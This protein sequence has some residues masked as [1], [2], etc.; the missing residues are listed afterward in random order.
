MGGTSMAKANKKKA[1]AMAPAASTAAKTSMYCSALAV[2]LGA[3]CFASWLSVQQAPL[4]PNA[5]FP[6]HL[7]TAASAS[8]GGAVAA[9]EPV[10][11]R[12]RVDAG[13]CEVENAIAMRDCR[14]ACWDAP[15]EAQCK[16]W[17]RLGHC[18][19]ASAFMLMRCPGVCPHHEI[20][21]LRAAP[22]DT[23]AHCAAHAASGACEREYQRG[24]RYFLAQCFESCGQRAPRL[25]LQAMLANNASAPFPSGLANAAEHV[26]DIVSVTVDTDDGAGR[27]VRVERLHD[28]PRVRLLHELISD[29]EAEALIAM[30]R[31]L[32]Q[33]S[34]TMA[35]Y[36]A[37]VRTSSTAYL[38]DERHPVLARVRA[39]IAMFSGYPVANIEP[40]QFL[41]YQPG[42]EYEFHNDFFD[43]CDVDQT[44]RGGERRMVRE[45]DL[46]PCPSRDRI[47][48]FRS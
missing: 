8:D 37:T 28:K 9:N 1:P 27:E 4:S 3:I 48:T 47:C 40:L 42:Q 21:C 20:T 11:C 25:L 26:G 12:E 19:A 30:G 15:I 44:F 10:S 13:D 35:A 23:L 14:Q 33:P 22:R 6:R 43:A 18:M 7:T 32:L 36:R 2:G 31:P 39:R 41:E 34:P 45:P 16:G 5:G 24:N 29:G 38:T 17:Q 46:N